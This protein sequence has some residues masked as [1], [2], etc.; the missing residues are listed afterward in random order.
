[1][2]AISG[3]ETLLGLK[4]SS[5]WG[6]EVAVDKLISFASFEP[7]KSVSAL[8]DN[9]NGL[10]RSML[11]SQ[12][13]GAEDIRPTVSANIGYKSNHEYMLA[14]FMGTSGA[15][16]EQTPSQADYLHRVLF[17]PTL[18]AKLLSLA[19]K[20]TTTTT[21]AYPSASVTDLTVTVANPPNFVNASYS[22][23]GSA[24]SLTSSTNTTTVLNALTPA[25]VNPVIV[26]QAD[27]FLINVS[28]GGAL[29]SPTDRIAI[30][31]FVINLSRPQESIA[32]IKGSAGNAQPTDGGLFAGTVTLTLKNKADHTYLTA[33]D[34]GTEYKCSMIMEG[35]QIGSGE[36]NTFAIYVPRMKIIDQPGHSV[37]DTGQNPLSITFNCLVAASNPTGLNSTYPYFEIINTTSTSLLA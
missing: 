31:S 14:Q 17:N 23:I 34:A 4:V 16:S 35:A 1:M 19:I 33:A 26:D 10:N 29:T 24:L 11:D 36:N 9:P 6:T 27:E 20:D 25:A 2:A 32:E 15:P 3:K 37:T 21:L 18:H 13:R 7:G 5:T 30:Q 8:Q 12:Q 22:L 28:S